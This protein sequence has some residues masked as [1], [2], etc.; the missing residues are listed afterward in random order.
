MSY[1]TYDSYTTADGTT[2]E[3]IYK[4]KS[5]GK[6]GRSQILKINA[7]GTS[8][9]LS[10]EKGG[11][12]SANKKRVGTTFDALKEGLIK[13][14]AG[15]NITYTD[16]DVNAV[17]GTGGFLGLGGDK[18]STITLSNGT[19]ISSG[20]GDTANEVK[21]VKRLADEI[22]NTKAAPSTTTTTTDDTL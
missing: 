17:G 10:S 18:A 13:A 3:A 9:I 14:E 16:D 12:A 4:G 6:T 8:E 19:V 7:D 22:V 1:R 15:E 21:T 2:Y 5:E 11:T 20:T